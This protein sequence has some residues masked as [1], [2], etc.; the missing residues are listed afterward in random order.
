MFFYFA[1]VSSALEQGLC[2]RGRGDVYFYPFWNIAWILICISV[3]EDQ[4]IDGWEDPFHFLRSQQLKLIPDHTT[5]SWLRFF[6]LPCPIR[7]Q[8]RADLIDFMAPD[9]LNNF[10][11]GL[12]CSSLLTRGQD[13]L[14]KATGQLFVDVIKV[15]K[16]WYF[17]TLIATKSSLIL[18]SYLCPSKLDLRLPPTVFQVPLLT[19]HLHMEEGI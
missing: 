16:Y 1:Q 6:D 7:V 9:S 8:I 18:V 10:H 15:E 14:N 12:G 17:S 13:S 5:R 2:I 19:L 4:Y 3:K 11:I